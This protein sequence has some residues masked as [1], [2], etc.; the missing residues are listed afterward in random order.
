MYRVSCR[1]RWR[2]RCF[3]TVSACTDTV[4]FYFFNACAH[5]VCVLLDYVLYLYFH[6][7]DKQEWQ[8]VDFGIV[9]G[10]CTVSFFLLLRSA[11]DGLLFS[12]L[13]DKTEYPALN[14]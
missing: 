7:L 9:A 2:P 8:N 5:T 3:W 13:L 10:V 12:G 11:M 14:L 6:V 4:A 1:E